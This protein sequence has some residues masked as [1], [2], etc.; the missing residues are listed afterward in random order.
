[1]LDGLSKQKLEEKS[2]GKVQ[3]YEQLSLGKC[4][5]EIFLHNYIKMGNSRIKQNPGTHYVRLPVL[6]VVPSKYKDGFELIMEQDFGT[7]TTSVYNGESRDHFNDQ[8]K[9]FPILGVYNEGKHS[10]SFFYPDVLT[11]TNRELSTVK[12]TQ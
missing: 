3:P 7:I 2:L 11:E 4:S 5:I 9:I 1:M 6:Y 12:E 10:Y 8:H